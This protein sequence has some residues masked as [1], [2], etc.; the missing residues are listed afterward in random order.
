MLLQ[1]RSAS[2]NKVNTFEKS[3]TVEHVYDKTTW[4]SVI[5]VMAVLE[6]N[7]IIQVPPGINWNHCV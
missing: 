1:V 2:Q 7:S 6:G 5:T 3:L 4:L